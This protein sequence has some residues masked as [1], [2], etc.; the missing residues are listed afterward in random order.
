[1][2]R[3]LHELDQAGVRKVF[4]ESRHDALNKRDI[5]LVDVL[6]IKGSISDAMV[7]SFALPRQEPMLWAPDAVAGAVSSA[8]FGHEID[9]VDELGAIGIIDVRL[10]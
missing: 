4:L 10:T 2:E 6:R 3:L 8:R 1:M 7:V 9:I 5:R